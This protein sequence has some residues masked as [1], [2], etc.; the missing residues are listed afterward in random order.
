MIGLQ[1]RL[2]S[3]RIGYSGSKEEVGLEHKL[4]GWVGFVLTERVGQGI[5]GE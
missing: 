2:P 4:D 5:S 3:F 1:C